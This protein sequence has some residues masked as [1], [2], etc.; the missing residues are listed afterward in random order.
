M[1]HLHL[2]AEVGHA[3]RAARRLNGEAVGRIEAQE[4]D[5]GSAAIRADSVARVITPL[6]SAVAARTFDRR[7]RDRAASP[8]TRVTSP[9]YFPR[10]GQAEGVAGPTPR[11]GVGSQHE[12]PGSPSG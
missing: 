4:P 9:A 11:K 5:P 12:L 1:A 6:R 2:R 8:S 3:V 10:L 7:R